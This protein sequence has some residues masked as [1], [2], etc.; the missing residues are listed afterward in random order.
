MV[1]GI[2][3]TGVWSAR[4]AGADATDSDNLRKLLEAVH[5]F[6]LAERTAHFECVLAL[7]HP[8]GWIRY[9]QGRVSGHIVDQPRGVNG[10]GYD[11]VFLPAGSAR[12]FAEMSGGEKDAISH[13]GRALAA[14]SEALRAGMI[15]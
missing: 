13:R 10:F 1:A 6:P 4:Y 12:T 7:A 3:L 11:P 5:P 14:F 2:R 9:F 15:R 8:D